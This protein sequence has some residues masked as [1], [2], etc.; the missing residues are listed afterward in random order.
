M[1]EKF[2][3][4]SSARKPEALSSGEKIRPKP[5]LPS[6]MH[7][8]ERGWLSANN[9][10]FVGPDKTTLVDTGYW[11]HTDQTLALV[12]NALGPRALD[13]IANTHLHSDHC[14]GNAALQSRYPKLETW[15]PPGQAAEVCNWDPEALTYLPTGQHCPRF[16][17]TKTLQ[18]GRTIRFGMNDWEI[19]AAAGH[20]PHAV[21]FFEPVKKLLISADS[22][23]ENGFG[24]VFPELEGEDAF[25][26]VALTLELIERLRPEI[27]IPGHGS[28]FFYNEAIL[29]GAKKR[30]IAFVN[31]PLRHARYAAKVLLKFKLLEMQRMS[32]LNLVDWAARTPYIINIENRF[33]SE[34]PLLTWIGDLCQDLVA[35]GAAKLDG[36]YIVNA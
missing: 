25:E 21:I 23:W 10:L 17:F 11:T 29:Q 5:V 3:G 26:Q 4:G 14:G 2:S 15:I 13:A 31:D 8:F 36:A 33:F 22:L 35:A 30:L 1:S 16:S 24:V 6:D 20:D 27:V 18:P 32:Y 19:H 9:I 7:V 12:Q 28:V 34:I